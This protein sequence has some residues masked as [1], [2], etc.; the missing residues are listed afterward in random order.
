LE[1]RPIR[2]NGTGGEDEKEKEL[3][4]RRGALMARIALEPKRNSATA[5]RQFAGPLHVDRMGGRSSNLSLA[6][7]RRALLHV[8]FL[9]S[10]CIESA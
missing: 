5:L 10:V 8:A 4:D 1:R 3:E 7:N 6:R 9:P 2:R